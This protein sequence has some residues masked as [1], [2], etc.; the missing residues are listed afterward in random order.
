M[1]KFISP[2]V[3]RDTAPYWDH[4]RNHELKLQRCEHCDKF[5]F[6]PTP[7][8]PH[9]GELGGDWQ[10]LSP[11]GKL[12]TWTEVFHPLDPRLKDEVPFILV[13]VDMDDGPRIG[14][15]LIG[16]DAAKLHIGMSV[17]A[18]F[19]DL[20]DQLTVVNFEPDKSD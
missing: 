15:R 8:C 9:C 6:P 14:G 1:K 11:R 3:D 16:A 4:L 5:R 18:R 2:V 13:L 12:C 20:D 19:D 7:A 10:T 17:V